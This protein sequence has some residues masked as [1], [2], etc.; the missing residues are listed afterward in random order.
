[1]WA[2]SKQEPVLQEAN[3]NPF[4]DQELAKQ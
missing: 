3:E 1:M 4:C 2:G